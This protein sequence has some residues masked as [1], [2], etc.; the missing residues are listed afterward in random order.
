MVQKTDVTGL[1]SENF[2]NYRSETV[3]LY[4]TEWNTLRLRHNYK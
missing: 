3:F 1:D 4:K 2:P